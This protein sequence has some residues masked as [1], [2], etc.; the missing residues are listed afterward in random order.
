MNGEH[1]T[2]YVNSYHISGSG[3]ETKQGVTY[4]DGWSSWQ[5]DQYGDGI[6]SIW[7]ADLAD[8]YPDRT[9]YFNGKTAG[10]NHTSMIDHWEVQEFINQ[11]IRVEKSCDEYIYI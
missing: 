5:S 3:I 2:W 10:A 9:F 11:L 1:I 7:S 4:A 6:V 8:M